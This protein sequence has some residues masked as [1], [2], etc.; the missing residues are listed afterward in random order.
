MLLDLLPKSPAEEVPFVSGCGIGGRVLIFEQKYRAS[1]GLETSHPFPASRVP[2]KAGHA[3][4]TGLTS[5][6]LHR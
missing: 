2:G 4:A 1:I 5:E 6:S 3:L